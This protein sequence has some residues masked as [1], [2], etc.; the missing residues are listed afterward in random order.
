MSEKYIAVWT[1][2]FTVAGVALAGGGVF[3]AIKTLKENAEIARAQF[4][5]SVRAVLVNYDDVHAKFRPSGIWAPAEGEV[6]AFTGPQ[7]AEEWA[8]V[9]LYMGTF[10]YCE[11]LIRRGLLEEDD[12]SD[13]YKY[14][15]IG[16]LKNIVVVSA[17]LHD[18]KRSWQDFYQLCERLKVRIPTAEEL[19]SA[20]KSRSAAAGGSS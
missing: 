7:N 6:Y 19:T 20:L 1:L 15:L 14:R 18:N 11:K 12:F 16:M 5:V 3:Y 4:W 13:A 10:E 2:V 9:E 17:K 8:R